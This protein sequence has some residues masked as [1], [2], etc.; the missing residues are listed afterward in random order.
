MTRLIYII[1][2]NSFAVILLYLGYGLEGFLIGQMLGLIIALT[3]GIYACSKTVPIKFTFQT[4]KLKEMLIFSTPLVF[5]AIASY[6]SIYTDRWMLN[7]FLG[8]EDV[9]IYSVAYKISSLITLIIIGF[10]QAF[11]PLVYHNYKNI[12]TPTEMADIFRYFT[13]IILPLVAL[14]SLFSEKILSLVAGEMYWA[15]SGLIPWMTF[16]IL[17]LNIYFFAPGMEIAKKTTKIALTNTIAALTNV[18]INFA[19]IPLYGRFGAVFGTLAGGFVMA[20]LY[21]YLSNKEY[22]VPYTW[23]RIL[24]SV[25][26]L[27]AL[28]L[29]VNRWY[30][31]Q[32]YRFFLWII[33]SIIVVIVMLN[34]S[35]FNNV[36][37]I[38]NSSKIAAQ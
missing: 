4:K 31:P 12:D 11:V 22:Y 15:G 7:H 27:L 23:H 2:Y 13:V 6:I 5:S 3:N 26:G 18:I 24:P 38:L 33:F 25:L 29:V 17:L 36:R 16:A 32:T 37:N 10:Q 21:F 30:I 35:D 14:I 1:S 34:R 20:S 9:G 28:I 8:M 19:L